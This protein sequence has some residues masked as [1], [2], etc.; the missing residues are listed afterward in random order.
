MHLVEKL[1]DPHLYG[2]LQAFQDLTSWWR[3]IVFIKS[4]HGLALDEAELAAFQY[5][6][7]R[8]IYNP[9]PGGYPEAVAIVGVQSG[10][11]TVAGIFL[12][13]GALEG[14]PGTMAVGV[15][16]DIRGS[17]RTLLKNA[18]AP[19]ETLPLFQ[20]EVS[21]DTADILELR[22]GT[23]LGAY[24][25]RPAA[26]R[27]VRACV[28]VMDE[29]A[30]F[31]ATD[32]RPTDVEMF[33]VARGRVAMTGGKIIAISSPYAQSGLLWELHRKHFANDDSATLVWQASAPEMNPLLSADYLARMEQD[34]PEAYRS[35][36]LGE[37]RA[38]VTSLLDPEMIAAC[39]EPGVRERPPQPR[40]TGRKRGFFDAG[41]G[42]VDSAVAA[43]AEVGPNGRA[44]LCAIRVWKAPFNPSG[45]IAEASA[46]YKSWGVHEPYGDAYAAEHTP[47][48]FRLHGLTYRPSPLN[49]SEIYLELV[50]LINSQSVVLLDHPELLRELRGLER[51]RGAGGRDK[52]DHRRGAHDDVANASAGAL[53]MCTQREAT[54]K[55]VKISGF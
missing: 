21:R 24:P 26:V 9:P 31:V 16:Q 39:V 5:H 42:R 6:T 8:S 29:V 33:R 10:K 4:V 52:V 17:M 44:L 45:V 50:P 20:A 27:G 12:A 53:I 13:D 49:R 46:F 47:E 7:G 35:E 25:C 28:M 1:R 51:R 43:V 41:G 11:S 19:F 37:F 18:R 3:W 34:D 40:A 36:V 38:G 32:G 2:G 55:M 15:A 23:S 22:R 14:A 54:C 48:Q 30:F